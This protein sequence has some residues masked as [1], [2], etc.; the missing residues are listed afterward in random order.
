M[1]TTA[2]CHVILR[3]MLLSST[4]TDADLYAELFDADVR[5]VLDLNAP[6]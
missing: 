2:F 1:N 5:R 6:L 4:M 3:L